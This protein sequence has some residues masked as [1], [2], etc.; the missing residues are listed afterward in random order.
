MGDRCLDRPAQRG[1]IAIG[2]RFAFP[3]RAQQNRAERGVLRLSH[4]LRRVRGPL[5]RVLDRTDLERRPALMTAAAGE[6]EGQRERKDVLA[7][8]G[9]PALRT[10]VARACT[11]WRP[12]SRRPLKASV[13]AMPPIA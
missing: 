8:P 10:A 12:G 3:D 9:G 6:R 1:K 11:T 7:E 4:R 2:A 13:F 5:R